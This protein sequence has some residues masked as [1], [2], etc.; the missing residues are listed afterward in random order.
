MKIVF[1]S[2]HLSRKIVIPSFKNMVDHP[3]KFDRPVANISKLSHLMFLDLF[4]M[5]L[6]TKSCLSWSVVSI[7]ISVA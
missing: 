5:K 6:C 3:H 1:W 4:H 7:G 2:A